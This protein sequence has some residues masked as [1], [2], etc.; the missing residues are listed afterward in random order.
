L[1]IEVAPLDT[2]AMAVEPRGFLA[3][4]SAMLG[5]LVFDTGPAW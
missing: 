1:R 2:T 5:V 4:M 3:A